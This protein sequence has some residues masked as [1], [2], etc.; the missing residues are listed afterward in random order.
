MKYDPYLLNKKFQEILS[1]LKTKIN[2]DYQEEFN[3]LM[4]LIKKEKATYFEY[5]LALEKIQVIENYLKTQGIELPLIL[6]YRK[7][8]ILYECNEQNIKNIQKAEELFTIVHKGKDKSLK[9]RSIY[10]L[11]RIYIDLARESEHLD[12][13]EEYNS[14]LEEANNFFDFLIGHAEKGEL[15]SDETLLSWLWELKER[16][17]ELRNNEINKKY[18]VYFFKGSEKHFNSLEEA[19]NYTKNIK[20]IIY[21]PEKYV[22]VNGEKKELSDNL[23]EDLIKFAKGSKSRDFRKEEEGQGTVYKRL[24]RLKDSIKELGISISNQRGKYSLDIEEKIAMICLKED[25]DTFNSF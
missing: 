1:K 25:Y 3:E 14:Y 19:E 24:Q 15:D 9:F 20:N 13:I 17:E 5:K 12:E 22:K 2:K 11:C 4:S 16:I 10:Y 7:A 18:I 21:Y 23:F 6:I 8:A